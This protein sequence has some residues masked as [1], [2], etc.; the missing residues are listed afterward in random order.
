MA[1][2]L[3][4]QLTEVSDP[5]GLEHYQQQVGPVVVAYGGR[6]LAAGAPDAKEGDAHPLVAAVLAFPNRRAQKRHRPQPMRSQIAAGDAGDAPD[7]RREHAGPL[8]TFSTIQVNG[9]GYSERLRTLLRSLSRCTGG[10]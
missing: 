6:Y 8:L 1:A 9:P 2:H 3:I 7:E 4:A 5:A 10:V